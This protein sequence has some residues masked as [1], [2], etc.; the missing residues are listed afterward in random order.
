MEGTKLGGLNWN[1]RIFGEFRKK[2][3]NWWDYELVSYSYHFMDFI[4][5]DNHLLKGILSFF[6]F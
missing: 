4:F 5:M 6:F 1:S 3:E 2:L